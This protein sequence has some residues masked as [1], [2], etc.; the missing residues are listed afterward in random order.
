MIEARAAGLI[1]ELATWS[2]D[3]ESQSAE[4]SIYDTAWVAMLCKPDNAGAV[5][6]TFPTSFEFLLNRQQPSGGWMTCHSKV[7]TILN[8]LAATLA[9]TKHR[10]SLG[11]DQNDVGA[12]LDSRASRAVAFLYKELT[13]WKLEAS[14]HVGF[15]L[16]VPALLSMLELEN[17]H[18]PFSSREDLMTLHKNRLANFHPEELCKDDPS[19]ML[20]L[21]EAFIGL[22]ETEKLSHH[23]VQGS[24]MRSPS[25][26]AAYLMGL[27]V[28]DEECETYLRTAIQATGTSGGVPSVFPCRIMEQVCVSRCPSYLSF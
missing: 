24:I 10:K 11:A 5:E 14:S 27:Q 25:S 22:V 16:L 12:A 7:D 19:S 21:L 8:T 28:W 9:L 17:I 4:P 6:W 26:T 1:G 3:I 18:L 2:H 20:Y 23:K 13:E 15:E